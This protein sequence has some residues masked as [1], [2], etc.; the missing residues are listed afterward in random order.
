MTELEPAIHETL[1]N[2]RLPCEGAFALATRL[3]IPVGRIGETADR[4]GVRIS[5][6]QLGLF[7][8][9][10]D[11][12]GRVTA[13]PHVEGPLREAIEARLIDGRLPCAAAWAIAAALERSKRDVSAAAEALR[14][15]I[16]R[17]Q[18]GC[19]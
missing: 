11:A 18:L 5:R 13:S 3:R 9:E 8:F 17:C 4:L 19:F 10:P 1:V 15:K 6:C 7:G 12:P 2:G 14:L 16:S